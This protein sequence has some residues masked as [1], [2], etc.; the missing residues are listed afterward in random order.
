MAASKNMYESLFLALA[1]PVS[2]LTILCPLCLVTNAL[3]YPKVL[4]FLSKALVWIS[5]MGP[6]FSAAEFSDICKPL[7]LTGTVSIAGLES[8][9]ILPSPFISTPEKVWPHICKNVYLL[10]QTSLNNVLKV[11]RTPGL[12]KPVVVITVS[13]T[14][15][16]RRFSLKGK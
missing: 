5:Y 10:S 6:A 9:C 7:W 3:P 4:Q 13:T 8:P 12:E 2:E 15:I 16:F 11:I 1:K 14:F